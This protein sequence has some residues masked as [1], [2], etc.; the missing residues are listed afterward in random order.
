MLKLSRLSYKR[1]EEELTDES[2]FKIF[3]A[4]DLFKEALKPKGDQIKAF[5]F[6]FL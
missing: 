2:P 6:L 5:R 3:A 4:V 1:H